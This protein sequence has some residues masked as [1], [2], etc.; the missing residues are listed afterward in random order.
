V[1]RGKKNDAAD[2]AAICEAAS[3]AD[4]KFVPVKT[5]EQQGQGNRISELRHQPDQVGLIPAG[6]FELAAQG[7][8]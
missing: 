4:V 1:K 2:A 3:R 6:S 7:A 5:L 8:F